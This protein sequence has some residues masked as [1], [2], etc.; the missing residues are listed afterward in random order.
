MGFHWLSYKLYSYNQSLV[1]KAKSYSS[2][3][4]TY[5]FFLF[6]FVSLSVS[7]NIGLTSWTN[8]MTSWQVLL[9]Q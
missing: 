8:L 5:L 6:S 4:N 2:T 7:F 3:E 9:N 1:N